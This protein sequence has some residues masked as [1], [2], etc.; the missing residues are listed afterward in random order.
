[1]MHEAS[2]P[3]MSVD[4]YIKGNERCSCRKESVRPHVKPEATLLGLPLELR[5]S[6]FEYV[7]TGLPPLFGGSNLNTAKKGVSS[8]HSLAIF[9]VC[10]QIYTETRLLPFQLDEIACLPTFGS[11]T[12]G[13]ELFLDG[14]KMFQR[15][16][17][18]GLEL[19]LL[20][21]VMEAWSLRA[22]LRLL[23]GVDESDKG[24]GADLRSLTIHIATRDLYLPQAD[25]LVGLTHILGLMPLP[26]GP[27]ASAGWVTEGLVHLTSL[28]TLKIIVDTSV[29][30]ATQVSAA[31][32]DQFEKTIIRSLPWVRELGVKWEVQQYSILSIDDPEWADFLS[33]HDSTLT[34]FHT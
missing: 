32:K 4:P 12:S 9:L 26:S 1:M 13:T 20:A 2:S 3:A 8:S 21:S 29:P 30:I 7:F 22:I 14:L 10:R 27:C 24:A 5:R 16:A 18:R 33:M 23:A 19:S 17:I 25:S 34:M 31:E 11:N 15:R 28:R 6:I